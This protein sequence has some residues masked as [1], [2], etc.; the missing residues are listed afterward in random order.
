MPLLWPSV[1]TPSDE[2]EAIK[3]LTANLNGIEANFRAVETA[4]RLYWFCKIPSPHVARSDLEGWRYIAAHA[5][6][7]EMNNLG[8]RLRDV[9]GKRTQS[10]P[11]IRHLIDWGA[12]RESKK[13]FE[14]LLPDAEAIRNS[15]AHFAENDVDPN[16][17]VVLGQC[18]LGGFHEPDV[19]SAP[20]RKRLRSIHLTNNTIANLR[21]VVSAY[22]AAFRMAAAELDQQGS[23]D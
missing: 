6:T 21:D 14:R 15:V 13:S 22:L 18:Y 1:C 3:A 9:A 16:D 7:F 5:C 17:H 10:L 2:I 23:L 12:I 19:F 11:S 20:Y 8:R 4:F